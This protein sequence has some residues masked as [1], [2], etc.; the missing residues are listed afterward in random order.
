[1]NLLLTQ[2]QNQDPTSPQDN[3]AFL[4]QLAQFS[5]LEQLQTANTTLSSIA[6]FFTQLQSSAAPV[7]SATTPTTTATT[8]TEGN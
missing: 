2:L 6:G 7:T 1:M 5:S 8:P 4:A 3:G